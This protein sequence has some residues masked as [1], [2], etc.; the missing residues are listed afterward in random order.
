MNA[1]IRAKESG[2]LFKLIGVISYLGGIEY[3]SFCKSP[4]DNQWYKY[5]N[6]LISKVNNFKEQ[7]V[8][9][10][11]PYILFYQKGKN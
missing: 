4:I 10:G 11:I 5:N 7:I 3:I 1:Y 8:D 9:Y 2:Y 6:D